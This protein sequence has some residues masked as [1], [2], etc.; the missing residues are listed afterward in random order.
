MW[1]R[2]LNHN[3]RRRRLD[4]GAAWFDDDLFYDPELNEIR[5]DR[6]TNQPVPLDLW[7]STGDRL[8]DWPLYPPD[9]AVDLLGVVPDGR[10][11]TLK[12]TPITYS[13]L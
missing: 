1:H 8:Q 2:S 10:T 3:G 13:L 4:A 6:S 7:D 12:T 5:F 11:T 9:V